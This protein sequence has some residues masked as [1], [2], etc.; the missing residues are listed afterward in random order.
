MVKLRKLPLCKFNFNR[1]IY[2]S[3]NRDDLV[4]NNFKP[5]V[6]VTKAIL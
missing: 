2:L 4:L 3:C 5:L 6:S 1:F